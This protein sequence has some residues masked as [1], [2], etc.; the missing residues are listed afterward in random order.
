MEAYYAG[1]DLGGTNIAI[2]I[3]TGEGRI[4]S[5]TVRKTNAPRPAEDLC[6]D[7]A[8]GVRQA[9]EQ[10]GLAVESLQWIGIGTPGMVDPDLGLIRYSNNLDLWQAPIRALLEERLHKPVYMDNDASAATFGEA[11]AGAGKGF[12]D[13]IM[14]TLGTGVGGGI[15]IDGKIYRGFRHAGGE[16]GHNCMIYKGLHCTCGLDG[17]MEMYCSVTALIR[18]TRETMQ[19]NPQSKMWELTQGSLEKVSGRTSF[20]AARQGD[21]VAQQV[22]DQYVDYLGYGISGLINIFVPEVLIVGGGI[23]R[24]GEALI[25]PVNDYVAR[26]CY[27]RDL[28]PR[29]KICA[30]QL[31]NDAGV[32]GAALLGKMS[33][34]NAYDR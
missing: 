8:Q 27:S 25:R 26:H 1:I 13:V 9:A 34:A 31:G 6:D 10:A 24:E 18:Q 7:M 19:A 23:S 2:G 32:I 29:T 20:D 33:G 3:V 22:V 21:P 12:R 11:M 4:V 17:C 14:V 16:L 30:A 15:V 5:S 28:K